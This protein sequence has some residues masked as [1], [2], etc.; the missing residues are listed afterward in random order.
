MRRYKCLSVLCILSVVMLYTS[1]WNVRAKAPETA[2]IVFTS[3]RNHDRE[4]YI[5]DANG[6]KEINLT[7]HPADDIQPTWSPTGERIL[8]VSDRDRFPRSW[9][10]YLMDADGSNVRRVFG[11]SKD[12]AGGE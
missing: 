2:K 8:F 7:E 9:D 3:L 12:R 5:M 10:L 1:V 6:Q 4:V 11:K